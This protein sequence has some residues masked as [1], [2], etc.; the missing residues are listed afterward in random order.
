MSFNIVDDKIKYKGKSGKMVGNKMAQ[1]IS[2]SLDQA[3]TFNTQP[4]AGKSWWYE[5]VHLRDHS[6]SDDIRWKWTK[7][8]FKYFFKYQ[9]IQRPQ[10]GVLSKAQSGDIHSFAELDSGD[11]A[12]VNMEDK[13]NSLSGRLK[14]IYGQKLSFKNGIF[15]N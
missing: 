14:T 10:L 1:T 2:V 6:I 4:Q 15:S 13:E 12:V 5:S 3:L 7:Q 9:K 8:V 11:V